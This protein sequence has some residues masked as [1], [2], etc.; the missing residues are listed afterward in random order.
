MKQNNSHHVSGKF[1]FIGAIAQVM[2][3][4]F[5]FYYGVMD[6]AGLCVFMLTRDTRDL[7]LFVNGQV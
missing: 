3:H 5:L 4:C 1:I 6:R 2:L 7:M